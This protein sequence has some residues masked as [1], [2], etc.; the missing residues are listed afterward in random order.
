M[1]VATRV[2]SLDY[3]DLNEYLQTGRVVIGEVLVETE[4]PLRGLFKL[5]TYLM[6]V[7][8][9]GWYCVVRLRWG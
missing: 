7:S 2:M 5:V 3:K 8:V 9:V 6:I 4:F 1:N